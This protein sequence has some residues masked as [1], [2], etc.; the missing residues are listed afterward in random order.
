VETDNPMDLVRD[1]GKFG[2]FVEYQV[3]PVVEVAESVQATQEGV[4]FRG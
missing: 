1:V 3:Y 4:E 2:P